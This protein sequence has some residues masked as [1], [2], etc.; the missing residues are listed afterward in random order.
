MVRKFQFKIVDRPLVG[1]ALGISFQPCPTPI[2]RLGLLNSNNC[3]N[4][5]K[6]QDYFN[7]I[8]DVEDILRIYIPTNKSED[9][10]V[11]PFLEVVI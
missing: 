2:L 8:Q 7:N 4:I 5:N 6:I 10:S 11:L 1:K 9:K 3:W